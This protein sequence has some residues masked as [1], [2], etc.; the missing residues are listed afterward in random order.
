MISDALRLNAICCCYF[1]KVWKGQIARSITPYQMS[2]KVIALRGTDGSIPLIVYNKE[3]DGQIQ[4]C[5]CLKLL[6]VQLKSTVTINR[7]RSLTT[8]CKAASNTG[9]DAKA[10]ST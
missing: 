1:S 8:T 10:H 4:A 9:R 5:N 2:I 7:D 6:Y 3:F